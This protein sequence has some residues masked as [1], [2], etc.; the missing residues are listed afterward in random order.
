MALSSE[1]ATCNLLPADPKTR[2]SKARS[3]PL[4]GSDVFDTYGGTN[5]VN[6]TLLSSEA[7][8][9]QLVEQ[10]SVNNVCTPSA[11]NSHPFSDLSSTGKVPRRQ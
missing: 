10:R 2:L 7:Y 11:M 4:P 8:A 3:L 1:R 5:V 6:A 9:V